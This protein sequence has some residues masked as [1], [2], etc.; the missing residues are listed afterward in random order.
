MLII[1]ASH[2]TASLS[3][4]PRITN[5]SLSV[6]ACATR[7]CRPAGIPITFTVPFALTTPASSGPG[8]PHAGAESKTCANDESRTVGIW[9]QTG[10]LSVFGKSFSNWQKSFHK[11]LIFPP[12]KS[13]FARRRGLLRKSSNL[14]VIASDSSKRGNMV[15]TRS[16]WIRELCESSSEAHDLPWLAEARVRAER[17]PETRSTRKFWRFFL[18]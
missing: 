14:I 17:T 12:Q 4:R 7:V 9:E 5:R 8:L 6:I 16:P 2:R 15:G 13:C 3:T 18:S 1:S 11:I 10:R